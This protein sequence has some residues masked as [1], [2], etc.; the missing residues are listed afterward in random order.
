MEYALSYASQGWPV[1]PL[2]PNGKQPLTTH[3]FKEATRD[4]EQI[5]QWWSRWPDANVGVVTGRQSGIVVLDVD[6]K[7]GVDGVVSAGELDL[8][9]TL[10]IKTPTGGY[11]LFY[12][13]PADVIVPRRI[14]VKPG[15]DILGEGGY[16]VAAGSIVNGA[17]YE[18]ARN[19]P[20]ADCPEVLINLAQHSVAKPTTAP[21]PGEKVATGSRN[22]Y[23]TAMGGKLRRIGFSQ[24]EL[25]AALL[26]I[27]TT[28]LAEP[29][30]ES[31]VRRV[32]TSV[33][34]YEPDPGATEKA[35][36]SSLLVA[37]PISELLAAVYPPPEFL[38]EP[39][40]VHPGLMMVYGPTGVAKTYFS[41][42]LGL[43]ASSN[44][45]ILK[46]RP[47]RQC[48]VLYVDGELGNRALQDRLRKL[49]RGHEFMPE[50]FYTLTRDDQA[51]G[52]IPD[53]NDAGSQ[54]RFLAS[55]PEDVEL[56]ILDNLSTLTSF[57]EGKEANSWESWDAM[58]RLLL[59]LRRRGYSVI[60]V[61]HANKGGTEQSG[62]ERKLHI[63]DTVVSLR[64]H[65]DPEGQ[66]PGYTDIEVH[67]K[68]GRNLPPGHVEPFI[69]TLGAAGFDK[70]A[71][72]WAAGELEA[73]KARQIEE[74][75]KL[76][77]PVSQVVTEVGCAS[78]FAY[79]VKDR[80][81]AAGSLSYQKQR[82]GRRQRDRGE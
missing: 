31:E 66:S 5:R 30:A 56:V 40:L 42:G 78:S 49:I 3:G 77:M 61:H 25:I 45:P 8:P 15:L 70:D 1:F 76:G 33:A 67:I 68:K 20:I 47:G 28:R 14:S 80:L 59:Q 9:P 13:A 54:I 2:Q 24:D 53:L 29:L 10:V 34:R 19:R 17:Y 36:E 46:Y 79:R 38:L 52:M 55:I 12:K 21:A 71:L 37:R 39:I 73:R 35:D 63:M 11:H 74:L 58:Q 57:T 7:H 16:V 82:P 44:H 60:V 6:R 62:T 81:V 43:S 32:A 48:G 72:A 75:L 4:P 50:R 65:D 64:K 26:V 51:G 69:A 23:L 22:Q 41:L 18:I 27:N